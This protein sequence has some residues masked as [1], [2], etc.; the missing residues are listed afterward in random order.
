[1]IKNN[2]TEY[3]FKKTGRPCGKGNSCV[4]DTICTV[5]GEHYTVNRKPDYNKCQP[6]SGTC[7]AILQRAKKHYRADTL[8]RCNVCGESMGLK[9]IGKH[10]RKHLIKFKIVIN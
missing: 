10:I 5:C 7:D 9:E 2:N 6:C 3:I 1:M 4:Y 8:I